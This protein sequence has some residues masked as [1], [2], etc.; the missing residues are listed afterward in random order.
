[1]P[2]RRLVSIVRLAP[3]PLRGWEVPPPDAVPASIVAG[4]EQVL[5]STVTAKLRLVRSPQRRTKWR[6]CDG[7]QAASTRGARCPGHSGGGG[8]A[9]C[10]PENVGIPKVQLRSTAAP[11]DPPTMMKSPIVATTDPSP[12]DP[13]QD[14]PLD[15]ISRPGLS[16]T[17]PSTKK[18]C[19]A[20]RATKSWP[21][22]RSSGAIT[23]S[24]YRPTPSRRRSTATAPPS[25]GT[26]SPPTTTAT[27]RCPAW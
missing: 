11:M 17:P 9:G 27:G 25:T 3:S 21:S 14:I 8:V 1:M 12:F 20:T 24:R 23:T 18:G 7:H 2:R 10:P 16:F 26:P 22:S 5:V 6:G 19:A 4:L 13:C 15:V